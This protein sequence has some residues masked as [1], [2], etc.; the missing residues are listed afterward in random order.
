[1]AQTSGTFFSIQAGCTSKL[2]PDSPLQTFA[3]ASQAERPS[4]SPA[5]ASRCSCPS[6]VRAQSRAPPSSSARQR[7]RRT[8]GH[9]QLV[10]A[11][12]GTA[13]TLAMS[14]RATLSSAGVGRMAPIVA[15]TPRLSRPND[16]WRN[17]ACGLYMKNQVNPGQRASTKVH[18]FFVFYFSVSIVD[19]A[20]STVSRPRPPTKQR[21]TSGRGCSGACRQHGLVNFVCAGSML[22]ARRSGCETGTAH[23]ART[24]N[25]TSLPL[26]RADT[27]GGSSCTSRT[28]VVRDLSPLA[29]RTVRFSGAASTA[30]RRRGRYSPA[31]YLLR[32]R[33]K[34]HDLVGTSL[35]LSLEE[36]MWQWGYSV[37]VQNTVY[38]IRNRKND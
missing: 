25:S 35:V 36:R 6:F 27:E 18:S 34:R 21:G 26:R 20:A 37:T 10:D 12:V 32:H 24:S 30:S 38:T 29:L 16:S 31:P 4:R 8:P 13:F 3:R 22:S 19:F 17:S 23:R 2:L 9:Q 11:R 33:G 15:A 7:L 14:A 1:V 28:S 5:S